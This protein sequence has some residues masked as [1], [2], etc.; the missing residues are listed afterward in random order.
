M[1]DEADFLRAL[2]AAPE[3]ESLKLVYADWLEERGDDRAAILRGKSDAMPETAWG[4]FMATLAQPFHR[5]DPYTNPEHL[6]HRVP[7]GLRGKLATF[8]G[9]LSEGS[10][11]DEGLMH[12]LDALV[13]VG[14]GECYYGAASCPMYPF[15]C[16][17][18]AKRRPLTG[19]DVLKALK[20]RRFR[21]D[22]IADLDVTRIGFP[23]YRPS[24]RNDE[25]HNDFSE[26]HLFGPAT[27]DEGGDE[28]TR[29]DDQAGTHGHL[30]RYVAGE[31]LW[32]VLLHPIPKGGY[33]ML[34]AVGASPHGNR[35]VG[36]VSHQVCHNLCD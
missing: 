17:L 28:V 18:K 35:L 15:I 34:F 5:H 8:A 25:I 33:V 2:L 27:D 7:I 20:A 22:H 16:E 31:Q 23:G 10:A 36:V 29:I 13:H 24:T 6:P 19:R 26:Q 1:T 30:K 14:W 4:A 12:D 11:W 9:Q 3:D 21:S 32:Y